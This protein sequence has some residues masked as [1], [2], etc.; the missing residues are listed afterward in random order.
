M[1]DPIQLRK[2]PSKWRIKNDEIGWNLPLL[3][4]ERSRSFNSNPKH[5]L[6]SSWK[7]GQQQ[8][9][10]QQSKVK[11]VKL[12]KHH[13]IPKS[14]TSYPVI[15]IKPFPTTHSTTTDSFKSRTTIIDLRN[16]SINAQSKAERR[17]AGKRIKARFD[18][19]WK[20][21][22]M[23]KKKGKRKLRLKNLV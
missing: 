12:K 19:D 14:H 22:K 13:P 23:E 7:G 2:I 16:T 5:P 8:Q 6:S 1:M 20:S 3:I 21:K 15:P 9:Q 10:Q 4:T 11:S 18:M 17:K